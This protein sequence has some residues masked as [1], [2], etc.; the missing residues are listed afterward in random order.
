MAGRIQ[1]SETTKELLIKAGKN[2]WLTA[3]E[4]AVQA[5]GKG[6]LQ[7]FWVTPKS[8]SSS[9]TES[10]TT[11]PTEQQII[12]SSCR[13]MDGG[14]SP[15]HRKKR[16]KKSPAAP[17][18]DTEAHNQRLVGWA[19]DVLQKLLLRVVRERSVVGEEVADA[20]APDVRQILHES[21]GSNP[22]NE[23]VETITLPKF[24]RDQAKRRLNQSHAMELDSSVTSQLREYVATVASM[25]RQ[26]PFHNFDHAA[27]VTQSASKLLNRI[28]TV[29]HLVDKPSNV[30]ED[31]EVDKNDKD[32]LEAMASNL[33][34]YTFGIVSQKNLRKSPCFRI[35]LTNYVVCTLFNIS[36][37]FGSFDAVCRRILGFNS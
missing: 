10:S 33:H 11:D 6:T 4:D 28:K 36:I 18:E 17:L 23:V 32:G 13:E 25:Y 9:A 34:T 24:D 20:E 2:H 37:D 19:A 7:T 1:C 35:N 15:K 12:P 21:A 8:S 5:K 29:D 27:H 26:N 14:A 22:I 3:R 30:M 31:D 16:K